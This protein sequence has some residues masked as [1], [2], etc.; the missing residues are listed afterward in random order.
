LRMVDVKTSILINAPLRK[1]AEYASNPDN[2]PD[3]Y[4][5]IYSVEWKT[6]KPLR[7]GSQIAFEA[8]FLGKKLMYTYEVVEYSDHKFMMSTAE[9]PFPMETTYT[10]EAQGA[11]D[12]VMSLRNRGEP[13]GFSRLFA[14]LMSFMMRNANRKDLRT[15]KLILEKSI[16]RTAK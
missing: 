12:T 16:A 11:N 10:F 7:I 2:A 1:V 14:P 15:I 8:K 6:P 9:G 3:W 5:N 13:S 4:I